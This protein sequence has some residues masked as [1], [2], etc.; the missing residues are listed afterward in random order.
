MYVKRSAIAIVALVAMTAAAPG[1]GAASTDTTT[2]GV[3]RERA[4]AEFGEDPAAADPALVDKALGPVEPSDEA[5]WNIV[6][7]VDRPGRTRTSTRPRS[8]RR[9]SAG[10]NS[11]ATPAPAASSS[12]ATPTVAA[13]R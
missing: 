12:W 6:L 8:T 7:G 5:S 11:R 3:G 2:A 13:T 9:W 10:V 1:Y 4:L